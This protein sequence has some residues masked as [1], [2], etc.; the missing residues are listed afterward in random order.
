MGFGSVRRGNAPLTLTLSVAPTLPRRVQQRV[1]GEGGVRGSEHFNAELLP[2]RGAHAHGTG[3]E[4]VMESVVGVFV[5]LAAK[6]DP[7]GKINHANTTPVL[8]HERETGTAHFAP[9]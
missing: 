3:L 5:G 6:G 4:V 7:L 9:R 1:Y 2:A 8:V